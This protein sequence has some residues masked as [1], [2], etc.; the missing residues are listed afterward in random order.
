M[1]YAYANRHGY[2]DVEPVE[3]LRAISAKTLDVREMKA[4]KNLVELEF[5]PGGFVGHFH[6]QHKQAYEITSDLDKHG[7]RHVLAD[8]PR[9]FYDFNF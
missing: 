2:S 1:T 9:K 5:S 3:I 8:R 6:N 7:Q 4:G